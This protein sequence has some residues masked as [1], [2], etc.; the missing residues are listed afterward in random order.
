[1]NTYPPMNT[2][3]L[4]RVA[5][6][7]GPDSPTSPGAKWLEDVQFATREAID[8][9][10][11]EFSDDD[12]F[13]LADSLVPIYTYERWQVFVD[14]AA[15]QEDVD[16]LYIGDRDNDL[17]TIAGIALYQIASRLILAICKELE[18]TL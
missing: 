18:V 8:Y 5:K 2:Y 15:W 1:M 11:G 13:E 14:L 9:A 12:V 4:A 17:T 10:K 3:Q 7:S 6:V 16:D